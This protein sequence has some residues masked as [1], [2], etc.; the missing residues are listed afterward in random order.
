MWF[1]VR[2]IAFDHPVTADQ[3]AAL[4]QRMGLEQ[5]AAAGS[6]ERAAR[7]QAAAPLP[8]SRPHLEM[9]VAT[10][11]RVLFIEIKA[12]HIFGWAEALLSDTDLVAGDG[13]AARLV[14]YIRADE[15]PHVDYLRTALTEMRDRTFV[16]SSGRRYAGHRDGR[17]LVGPG[18]APSRWARCETQNRSRPGREVDAL[19]A[20]ARRGGAD[21]LEQF[22][23]LGDW[24]PEA[25]A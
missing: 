6:D 14:S 9:L 5:A 20:P 13:E 10:M 23:A 17:R 15:T 12:F 25:A 7:F 8:G 18:P 19:G 21:L 1:A 2:D 24:R 22:H 11:C 3:T 16:G 4:L